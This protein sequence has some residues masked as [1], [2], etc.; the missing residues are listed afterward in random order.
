MLIQEGQPQRL[1]PTGN[2]DVGC[3]LGLA[4]VGWVEHRCA[5]HRCSFTI[6]C[7]AQQSSTQPTTALNQAK[8]SLA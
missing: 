1:A 3:I 6:G 4:A 5:Q 8:F 7:W 2:A